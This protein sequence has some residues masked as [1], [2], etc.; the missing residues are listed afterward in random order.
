MAA[1]ED[2]RAD[3]DADLVD[4]AGAEQAGGEVGAAEQG[5]VLARLLLDL[6]QVGRDVVAE[7]GHWSPGGVGERA[8]YH[9]LVEAVHAARHRRVAVKAGVGR[10]E[11]SH[12]LVGLA[13]EQ[14][15]VR[16]VLSRRIG[17][18]T[19]DLGRM[20]GLG[21]LDDEGRMVNGSVGHWIPSG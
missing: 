19:E 11:G 21:A 8:G 9:D 3:H 4:D 13:A 17:P 2:D 5:D 10:P 20:R 1:A 15:R 14:K 18:G 7:H 6:A 16:L 12:V